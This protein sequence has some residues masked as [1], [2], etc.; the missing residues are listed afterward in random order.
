M[1]DKYNK[2]IDNRLQTSA[3]FQTHLA[4]VISGMNH[5]VA[6]WLGGAT[7]STH[8]LL[9]LI[10][11]MN[12]D[13]VEEVKEKCRQ[14]IDKINHSINQSSNIL[15]MLSSNVKK[16]QSY[17]MS[18]SKL[19]D[20]INSWVRLVLMDRLIKNLISESNIVI[21]S[22]SLNFNVAHSPMLLSQIILNLAKNSIEHNPDILQDLEIKIYGYEDK[23]T[24]IF[25]DN[26]CGISKDILCRIFSPNTT[27]KKDDVHQH[28]LGLSICMDYCIAMGATIWVKSEVGQF[29]RFIIKF[30]DTYE[31][32][33]YEP[34]VSGEV[35]VDQML[36][37]YNTK[38]IMNK[39]QEERDW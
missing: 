32:N 18:N 10:D 7:N 20:T 5:E 3:S 36:E 30:D 1:T 35:N 11:S 37:I 19:S 26:G 38:Q 2:E 28:G 25:E 27:S 17:S 4:N 39:K 29:T 33:R 21:D 14:K 9:K 15:S 13:N 8:R 6:P 16:L 24:L 12:A 22:S 31:S 34:Q 23:K